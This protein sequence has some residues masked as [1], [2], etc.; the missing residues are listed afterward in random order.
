MSHPWLLTMPWL[1]LVAGALITLVAEP[2]CRRLEDK[3]RVLG[4][5]AMLSL[6]ACGGVYAWQWSVVSVVH[7]LFVFEPLRAGLALAVIGAAAIAIGGLRQSLARDRHPGGEGYVLLLVSALGAL[8]LVH[9]T[10]GLSVFAGIETMSLPIYALV[11]LHRSRSSS[12]EAL[13][14]Y[15]IMGA[16]FSAVLLYGIALHYGATGSL[17]LGATA[18]AGRDGLQHLGRLLI[19]AGLLFKLGAVPFHFWTPDAYSG[20]PMAVTG[21]MGA[22]VKI[23]GMAVLATLWVATVQSSGGQSDGVVPLSLAAPMQVS[24]GVTDSV[25]RISVLLLCVAMLS[26][27]LGNFAALGQSQVRRLMAYSSIAHIGYMLLAFA[28]PSIFSMQALSFSLGSV[29][30]Y[31]VAYAIALAACMSALCVHDADDAQDS[32]ASLAGLARR[33]P[34]VGVVAT[35]ALLSL[36]GLPPTSGF[37]GKYLIFSDL[38]RHGHSLLAIA[39]ILLAVVGAVYYLR[40]IATLWAPQTGQARLAVHGL[41]YFG[42]TLALILIFG[43]LAWPGVVLG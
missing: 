20:A 7:S 33:A 11:A 12:Q 15:F 17:S 1:V 39:G 42:L 21:F 36:A 9:A 43:L 27:L 4:W 24:M 31:V 40:L 26:I 28:L 41:N 2:L 16:A 5:L 37:L 22:V 23:G 30:Y 14:K 38:V 6:L 13:L 19:M 35:V 3:H 25:E 10:S 34:Y 32:L 8:V 18:L 29:C